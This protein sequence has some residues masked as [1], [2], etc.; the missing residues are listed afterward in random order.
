MRE[1][2]CGNAAIQHILRLAL[3]DAQGEKA[4]DER[5]VV[6]PMNGVPVNAWLQGFDGFL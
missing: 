4:L 6:L 5:D 3:E 1:K 2:G